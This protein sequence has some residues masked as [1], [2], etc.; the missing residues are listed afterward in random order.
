VNEILNFFLP[1]PCISCEKPGSPFCLKCQASFSTST[2][3]SNRLV[4][5]GFA[6]CEYGDL[7]AK[8]IN[9]IKESG[10]TSLIGP[11]AGLMAKDWPK[12][13]SKPTLIP[14]PSSAK[15]YRKRGYHHILKLTAALEKRIPEAKSAYLLRSIGDRKDQTSLTQGERL[16][17]LQGAF[18]VDLRG[19]N[20][21]ESRIVLVDDVITSGATIQAA[22]RG[23]EEAGVIVA[24]FCVFADTRP[25]TR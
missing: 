13:F 8:I 9:A 10:Q 5:Q 25:R 11:V 15:N 2:Q 3:P 18:S 22:Q 4:V 12:E 23:L 19:F 6:F 1:T 20:P 7:S 16:T 14:I 21:G 24:G 17:N